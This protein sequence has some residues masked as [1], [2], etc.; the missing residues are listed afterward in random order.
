MTRDG[1]MDNCGRIVDEKYDVGNISPETSMALKRLRHYVSEENSPIIQRNRYDIWPSEPS[2]RITTISWDFLLYRVRLS[3]FLHLLTQHLSS[4]QSA[5]V[6]Y[7]FSSFPPKLSSH[8]GVLR[9]PYSKESTRL[10]IHLGS[11]KPISFPLALQAGRGTF[12]SFSQ[13][14][15]WLPSPFTDHDAYLIRIKPAS[16]AFASVMRRK[17]AWDLCWFLTSPWVRHHLD[18]GRWRCAIYHFHSAL[19]PETCF[20][21]FSQAGRFDPPLSFSLCPLR[22]K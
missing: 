7:L 9:T 3:L 12:A 21:R 6:Y 8:W 5:S 18:F 4:M 20:T 14:E 19:Q 13:A 11:I 1:K 17:P 2:Y 22:Y 16:L 15:G 10:I